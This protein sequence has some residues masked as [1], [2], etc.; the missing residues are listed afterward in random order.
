MELKLDLSGSLQ[1][2]PLNIELF[3]EILQEK[4]KLKQKYFPSAIVTGF[5]EK[6]QMLA[7]SS[8]ATLQLPHSSRLKSF[9]LFLQ[10][11]VLSV[12]LA[13]IL[14]LSRHIGCKGEQ[15]GTILAIFLQ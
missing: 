15:S 13:H 10:H 14:F 9:K 1:L 3:T 7:Y 12:C 5:P 8:P 6:C 4:Y 11:E 2:P